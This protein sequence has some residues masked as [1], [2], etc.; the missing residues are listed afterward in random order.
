M[1]H[2]WVPYVCVYEHPSLPSSHPD[3]AKKREINHN[4][5]TVDSRSFP[6]RGNDTHTSFLSFLFCLA[7][8][9]LGNGIAATGTEK[10]IEKK[11]KKHYIIHND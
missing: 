10:T 9:F 8:W 5:Q 7:V 3:N 11:E 6:Y 2:V 4:T 1:I